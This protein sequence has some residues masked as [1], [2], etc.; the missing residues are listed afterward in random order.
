MHG[1][2]RENPGEIISFDVGGRQFATYQS[3]LSKCPRMQGL[4]P[5]D[6]IDRDPDN[7]RHILAWM[8]DAHHLIPESVHYELD[9]YGIPHGNNFT[10]SLEEGVCFDAVIVE[11]LRGKAK[12][13]EYRYEGSDGPKSVELSPEYIGPVTVSIPLGGIVAPASAVI[14]LS[15]QEY[16]CIRVQHQPG[17]PRGPHA[18]MI[19]TV[20]RMTGVRPRT[21]SPHIPVQFT[22]ELRK[23]VINPR[24]RCTLTLR[25]P[26]DTTDTI[27]LVAGV[28]ATITFTP[29]L[30]GPGEVALNFDTAPPPQVDISVYHMA[31]L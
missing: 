8:R 9:W 26:K 15:T 19:P 5:G 28:D 25:L 24:A 1:D 10:I 30:S 3:T 17:I 6:F 31:M 20:T 7:F 14:Q 18:E 4:R 22:G 21:D 23:L 16:S 29:P 13:C 11:G 12:L 2:S 27:E